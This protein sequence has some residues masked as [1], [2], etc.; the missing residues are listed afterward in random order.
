M[1]LYKFIQSTGAFLMRFENISFARFF[2]NPM[3]LALP[4]SIVTLLLLPFNF[5]KFQLEQI[6]TFST[7]KVN[8]D[9]RQY[10]IDM[11]GD[12][13]SETI[14]HFSNIIN[15][16]AIKI[17]NSHNEVAG[18]WNF[19]GSH[20]TNPGRFLCVDYDLD[21]N[22]EI[23]S[24][25]HRV[26]SVFLGGI[27]PYASEDNK[28][29]VKDMFLDKI[30]YQYDTIDFETRLFSHDLDNDGSQEIIIALNAG[31]SEQPRRIFAW[32]IAKDTLIAS[33]NYG[34][35]VRDLS[36]F[37]L[38]GDGTVELFTK[39]TSYENI[40]EYKD[41][42]YNDYSLWFVIF[43]HKLGF[44]MEPLYMGT[45]NGYVS[46]HVLDGEGSPLVFVDLINR[47]SGS[48]Q[49]FYFY[50]PIANE[51]MP[52]ENVPPGRKPFRVFRYTCDDGD[53]ILLIDSDGKVFDMNTRGFAIKE[54]QEFE[55]GINP[56]FI[57][58]LDGCGKNEI[59]CVDRNNELLIL[60]DDLRH[61]VN[62]GQK[63]IGKI[64][65]VSLKK[66]GTKKAHLM[67]QREDD[68]YEYRLSSSN[69]YL[70]G[71]LAFCFLIYAAY[72]LAVWLILFGQRRL[73]KNR[74][75][76]EQSLL[77]LKLKSIRNQM[78]RISFENFEK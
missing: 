38:D 51:L 62:L 8:Q 7:D 71:S 64:T 24:I 3:F 44:E 22:K 23:F 18:Q 36:F 17:F 19:N 31:H 72:V 66:N 75:A 13:F 28:F 48:V 49:A 1:K 10:H 20:G 42:P 59:L 69:W 9:A 40:E 16:C 78:D 29:I 41:I 30:N 12:D 57:E 43:D 76:R 60:T 68:I 14:L 55:K 4:F 53:K 70:I 77:E 11:D 73:L 26:D 67:I 21:G 50:D 15:R 33:P 27:K 39:T 45:G 46:S 32:N 5:N 58:D 65:N 37:D 2:I 34:F 6:A 74:F 52:W 61:R 56:I 54:F 35:K 25:Y 47:K 63:M